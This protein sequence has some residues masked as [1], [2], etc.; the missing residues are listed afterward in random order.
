MHGRS[1]LFFFA[2]LLAGMA[3]AQPPSDQEQQLAARLERL[4]PP[5]A[6]A[7]RSSPPGGIT[8]TLTDA[9]TGLPIDDGFVY[10]YSPSGWTH[11]LTS[12]DATGSYTFSG[13]PAASFFVKTSVR[14]YLDE[15]YDDLPCPLGCDRTSGT[16]VA[17][18]CGA[19]TSG[20]D[21]TLER[22]GAI[23]GTVTDSVTGIPL[24]YQVYVNL[25]DADGRLVKRQRTDGVG[26]YTFEGLPFGA[27]FV[28]TDIDGYADERYD[29]LPC[30][31]GC[32]PTSGT[33][34]VVT[35]GATT[36][37]VDFALSTGGTITGTITDA[38]TGLHLANRFFVRLYDADGNRQ[39]VWF[40]D[41]AGTYTF[42]GLHTGSYFVATDIGGYLDV[43]YDGM[44]CP[45]GCDPTSGTPI[46][47]TFGATTSGIDFALGT[48]GAI[49]GTV[50]DA[51]TGLPLTSRTFVELYD[52]DGSLLDSQGTDAAGSYRFAGLPTG[53]YFV[54][55][56]AFDYFDELYDDLP[57]PFDCDVTGGAPIVVTSGSTTSGVDFALHT[58]GAITGTVT[59][60]ATGLPLANQVFVVLHDAGGRFRD[61]ELTDAF[62]VYTFVGLAAGTYFVRT[63]VRGHFDELYDNLPCPFGCAVT[64]GTPI[65]VTFGSTTSGIDLA[66]GDLCAATGDCAPGATTLCLLE[67][68]R[69]EVA[70]SFETVQGGGR[71]GNARAVPLDPLNIRKGGIFYFLDSANPEFLVKVIDGCGVNDR[72]W[73]FYA[74]TTNIGFELTVRDTATESTKIYSNPDLNT[75]D[76]VADV[77]AFATCDSRAGHAGAV[78]SSRPNDVA[79]SLLPG[80]D[81]D[82]EAPSRLAGAGST[83]AGDCVSDAT[84]LCLPG[85]ARFAVSVE[86]ETVQ[87]GG[88]MGDAQAVPLDVLGVEKGGVLYFFDPGN[89][90]F[91][92]KII[93]GCGVNNRFW[94]F[95]A[96]TTNIGFELTVTDTVT[97]TTKIYSN[98]DLNPALTVTDTQAFATCGQDTIS[99]QPNIILPW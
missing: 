73:V 52:A 60:A 85:D 90:E 98:P 47:V 36:S 66:L 93:D 79:V 42:T 18:T 6:V 82:S 69:F 96:A 43:L 45:I 5:T 72:F 25:Y 4:E 59:D 10:L 20:I 54:A 31:A 63:D 50:T 94:V 3:S 9:A 23:T 41:A 99:P 71:T 86:F 80:G 49:A 7:A 24:A 74:A 12:P 1:L 30:P 44:P 34:I 13:L 2:L 29:D 95:Y 81:A 91:L 39:A 53:S 62:G 55:T 46:A 35:A 77:D 75:A 27:Y 87:A 48:G 40:T 51:A 14:G 28:R 70:V 61:L 56:N 15:L 67:D 17:V 64:G 37:E 84:T 26:S 16:P 8:G 22:G 11:A 76:T 58:G 33:P 57:C 21:F 92:V 97:D 32:D 78:G 38:S 68:N 19:M 83:Q 89:P 88:R 65:A